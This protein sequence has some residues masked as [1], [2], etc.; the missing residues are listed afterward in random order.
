ML[1]WTL[2][3]PVTKSAAIDGAFLSA[4]IAATKKPRPISPS[5]RLLRRS[6][7]STCR[8]ETSS[9]RAIPISLFLASM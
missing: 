1:P 8:S 3:S 6:M 4:D 9:S 2:R 5:T 7:T